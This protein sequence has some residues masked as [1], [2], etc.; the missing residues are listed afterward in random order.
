MAVGIVNVER[1]VL[2]QPLRQRELGRVVVGTS[3][4]GP[5]RKCGVLRMD[6]YVVDGRNR[7]VIPLRLPEGVITK[8]T[9][10]AA[11]G[12][13]RDPLVSPLRRRERSRY[14]QY[15]EITRQPRKHIL[16]ERNRRNAR[17]WHS[18]VPVI[19]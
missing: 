6:E 17:D 19:D 2:S 7:Q 3:D 5:G 4:R 15:A 16:K 1:D 10:D 14:T 8:S 11:H 13:I 12:G 18:L 9:S